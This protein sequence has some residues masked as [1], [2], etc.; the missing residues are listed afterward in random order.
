MGR[1]RR[2]RWKHEGMCRAE[3]AYGESPHRC[4]VTKLERGEEGGQVGG[5]EVGVFDRGEVAAAVENGPA[6]DIVEALGELAR[7]FALQDCLVREEGESR[8]GAYVCRRDPVPAVV[9]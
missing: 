8:W 7:G 5:D 4:G 2:R 6:L 1:R 3:G 9:P